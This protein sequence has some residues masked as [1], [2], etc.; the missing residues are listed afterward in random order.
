MSAQKYSAEFKKTALERMAGC[1]NVTALAA[2]LGVR[3][4]FLY[5]WR[6]QLAASG[7]PGLARAPGRPLGSA[8]PSRAGEVEAGS[9]ERASDKAR[10]A[11][12]E[13]LLGRKQ[14]EVEFFKQVFE[15]VKELPAS[16]STD[17]ATASTELS[18]NPF[19]SKAG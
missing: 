15:H 1:G 5:L 10:I 16:N 11:E 12:L 18:A 13:R 9:A 3:R 7:E 8:K 14:L 6:E 4:K 2:E 17:G 19:R